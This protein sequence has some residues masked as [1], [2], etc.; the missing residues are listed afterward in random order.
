MSDSDDAAEVV[1]DGG[2]APQPPVTDPPASH[3][4]SPGPPPLGLMTPLAALGLLALFT[5]RVL[6]PALKGVSV[7]TGKLVYAVALTGDVSSQICAFL[8]MMA[9]IVIVLAA[10]RSRLP[11]VVRLAALGLGG[12]AVLP[13]VWALHEPV[14]HLSAALVGVSAS[15]L[16]LLAVPSALRAPFARAPGVV[17]GLVAL[18]GLVRLGAVALAFQSSE[19]RFGHLAAAAREVATGAFLCDA[20][21]VAVALAWVSSRRGSPGR[22]RSRLT[23]PVTLVVLA[24]ALVCTRQALAGQPYDAHGIDVLFWRAAANLRNQPEAGLPQGFR[25]FVSFLAPL[26]AVAALRVRDPLAAP[27]GAA[28][29]LALASRGA[30]EMP[31]CALMLIVG[32]LGAAL[33]ASDGRGVWAA[34]D[35]S[36][37]S[38]LL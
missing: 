19:P 33:I 9:A 27:F 11:V 2:S 7:G 29:A 6:A 38:P 18:G 12:F 4:A 5:G 35:R 14:N 21:A 16:A 17:I 26:V 28:V 1:T 22:E 30:V 34:I 20:V 24:L 31:P 32:A 10:S 8:G 13:T 15:L 25:V 37:R 3:P 23:S 36:R